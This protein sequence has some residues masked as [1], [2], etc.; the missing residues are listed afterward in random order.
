[1][2]VWA[3]NKEMGPK[4]NNTKIFFNEEPEEDSENY[5]FQ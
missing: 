4:Y 2:I 5:E 1:M 3:P